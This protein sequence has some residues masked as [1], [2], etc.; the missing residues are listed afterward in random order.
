MPVHA[1][2]RG[3]PAYTD[4]LLLR[5]VR[6]NLVE[7][8]KWC[9]ME[10]GAFAEI[11]VPVPGEDDTYSQSRFYPV[12]K[13]GVRDG[14][15]WQGQHSDWCHESG[16]EYAGRQPS[17]ANGIYVDGDPY[18]TAATTGALNRCALIAL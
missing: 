9:F 3:Q 15:I 8:L 13:D 10:T 14:R 16:L 18:L 1:R 11:A 12:A 4:H 7:Y 2:F 17:I 5:T 6:E